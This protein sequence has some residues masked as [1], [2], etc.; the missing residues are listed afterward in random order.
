MLS[1]PEL[2]KSTSSDEAP[3]NSPSLPSYSVTFHSSSGASSALDWNGEAL[4]YHGD[5]GVAQ[6]APGY[7]HEMLGGAFQC[8]EGQ[9]IPRD[10]SD[11][12]PNLHFSF[13]NPAGH[14]AVVDLTGS[15]P[16]YSGDL[17]VRPQR[18]ALLRA[19]LV[20]L[21]LPGRSLTRGPV[22]SKI[23]FSV[24]A[25]LLAAAIVAVAGGQSPSPSPASL[26]SV[27]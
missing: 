27:V 6:T 21:P 9:L 7:F 3:E 11:A 2:P 16:Q 22:P 25:I 15:E 19:A 8:E 17:P 20:S 1:A 24:S 26:A 12:K 18:E 23:F 4:S 13:A 5:I 14:M 10:A